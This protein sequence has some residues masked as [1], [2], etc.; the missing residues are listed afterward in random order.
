M[1]RSRLVIRN[2]LQKRL[3]RE[4]GAP[5]GLTVAKLVAGSLTV[6]FA[7]LRFHQICDLLIYWRAPGFLLYLSN[8][9]L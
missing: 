3:A 8:T 2:W 4:L 9:N 6:A 7:V 5:E 1:V